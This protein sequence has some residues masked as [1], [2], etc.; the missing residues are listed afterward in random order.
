[1]KHPV[2]AFDNRGI[3]LSTVTNGSL[4]TRQNMGN[5]IHELAKHFKW[6]HINLVGISMGAIV[7]NTFMASD[8]TD[9]QVDRLILIAGAYKDSSTG[10]LIQEIGSWLESFSTTPP[11]AR[12]WTSFIHRL[13]LACLTPDYIKTHPAQI[14]SFLRQMD[15]GQGRTYEKFMEQSGALGMYDMT[16]SLK[17]YEGRGVKTLVMHG[18]LD[19]AIP[20]EVGRAMAELIESGD[21]EGS[22]YLEYPDGGH[23]LFETNP[24]SVD[25]MVA[26][27]DGEE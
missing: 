19:V 9:V 24:E 2:L 26:F 27:L 1:M 13:M 3:G 14:R 4:I 21:G 16:E 23:V 6:T 20:V 25:D 12:E 17:G 10:P 5:D 18:K 22:K 8:F 15:E 7:S 11:P